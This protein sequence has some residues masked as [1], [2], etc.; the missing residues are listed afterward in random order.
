MSESRTQIARADCPDCGE[1]I[2]IVGPVNLGRK[3]VCPNCDAEL[4][5]IQANP[6]ELDWVDDEDEIEEDEDEDW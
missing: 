3:V 1:R 6:V 2:R 4:E 5:I